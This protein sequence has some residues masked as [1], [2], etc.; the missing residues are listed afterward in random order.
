MNQEL[1][2]MK[3]QVKGSNPAMDAESVLRPLMDLLDKKSMSGRRTDSASMAGLLPFTWP[4]ICTSSWFICFTQ[5]SITGLKL[6]GGG[7]GGEGETGK[8]NDK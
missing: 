8:E 7:G 6:R 3:G 2:Q 1:V 4:F 5:S